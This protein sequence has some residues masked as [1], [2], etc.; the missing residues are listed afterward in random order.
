MSFA[1]NMND[2]FSAH[3][4]ELYNLIRQLNNDRR[5]N[6]IFYGEGGCGKSE[7]IKRIINILNKRTIYIGMFEA[8]RLIIPEVVVIEDGMLNR[9]NYK[10]VFEYCYDKNIICLVATNEIDL[11]DVLGDMDGR[12]IR[13]RIDGFEWD[14]F[15]KLVRYYFGRNTNIQKREF[16]LSKYQIIRIAK[17]CKTL[18]EFEIKFIAKNI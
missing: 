4:E 7:I 10:E 8:V 13:Q 14:S 11:F 5:G 9:N 15:Q 3:E 1:E 17:K 16:S 12:L 2:F 18:E 6:V